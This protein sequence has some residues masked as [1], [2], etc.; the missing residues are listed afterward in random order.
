MSCTPLPKAA[1][2]VWAT[3]ITQVPCLVVYVKSQFVYTINQ[4]CL[5]MR[6]C[7]LRCFKAALERPCA[8]KLQLINGWYQPWKKSVLVCLKYINGATESRWVICCRQFGLKPRTGVYD[9]ASERSYDER[10]NVCSYIKAY[11]T[12]GK[13]LAIGAV[14]FW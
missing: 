5:A 6:A 9:A 10:L 14:K 7:V 2:H 12:S 1:K 11:F 4:T 3:Q 8:G 13:K